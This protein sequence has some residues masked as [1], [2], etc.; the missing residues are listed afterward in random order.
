M[1]DF[2]AEQPPIVAE[3][4]FPMDMS[5]GQTAV[6]QTMDP[7]EKGRRASPSAG[8]DSSMRLSR[9]VE[10]LREVLFHPLDTDGLSQRVDAI[11]RDLRLIVALDADLALFE[12][13]RYGSNQLGIYSVVHAV[14]CAMACGFVARRLGWP[15]ESTASLVNA[16][17]TMNI[18][19]TELQGT[20]ATQTAP[21][22]PTAKQA[23]AIAMH[24]AR[25]AEMLRD[26][27]V[28]DAA[29]LRAVEEH[30]ERADGRGYPRGTHE[31]SEL[32]TTLRYVDEFFAKISARASR[33]AMPLRRAARQ[34]YADADGRRIVDILISEFGLYPPGTYV[35][36]ANGDLGIVLR[37][38]GRANTPLAIAFAN[39]HGER[40]P[41]R[42]Y[43]DTGDTRYAI[44]MASTSGSARF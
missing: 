26:A 34:L 36:L 28:C 18:A 42:V 21:G 35:R 43:R 32:A 44:V 30:H 38:G 25:G 8:S 41:R 39:R 33:P 11:A 19:M 10:D 12:V 16:A 15:Q 22:G 9:V 17:L 20:L 24:P 3:E 27:G 14:Q 13:H 5:S 37:R 7:P 31:P 2:S 6:G 1:R 29:W 23:E 4:C 40:L